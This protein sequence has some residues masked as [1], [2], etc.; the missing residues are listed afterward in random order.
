MSVKEL[1]FDSPD[2]YIDGSHWSKSMDD[3]ALKITEKKKKRRLNHA[4]AMPSSQSYRGS[5]K[6]V[7]GTL[8][9]R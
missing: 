9:R 1:C 3:V 7:G 8:T 2:M 5:E 6:E 4:C